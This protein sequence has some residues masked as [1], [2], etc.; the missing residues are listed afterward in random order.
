M[1]QFLAA[2]ISAHNDWHQFSPPGCCSVLL[3]WTGF[4]RQQLLGN[5]A[6]LETVNWTA[7]Q[8]IVVT[9]GDENPNDVADME[10]EEKRKAAN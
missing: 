10:D 6:I 4:A 8:R 7:H 1:S 5:V 2:G 3:G 9:H